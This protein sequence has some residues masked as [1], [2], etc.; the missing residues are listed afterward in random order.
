MTF[1]NTASAPTGKIFAIACAF[2]AASLS[3]CYSA[4]QTAQAADQDKG[5]DM[6]AATP[7]FSGSNIGE[8]IRASWASGQSGTAPKSKT[9]LARA[10]IDFNI[11]APK[12]YVWRVLTD[13]DRYP[14]IFP[15]LRACQVLKREGDLVYIESF[16]KPQLFV[17]QQCQHTINDLK[18]KPDSLKWRLVDGT[19]KSVEGEWT[20]KASDDNECLIRYTLEV[21]PG[22]AIPRAVANLALKMTQKEIV[23]NI[24]DVVEKDYARALLKSKL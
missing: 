17:N 4:S 16:L 2:L 3:S 22:P 23:A 13:F 18:N 24:K 21:D 10:I 1:S 19:F 12:E 9:K 6:S 5:K 11:H 7:A 8:Q 15:K 20:L 14:R